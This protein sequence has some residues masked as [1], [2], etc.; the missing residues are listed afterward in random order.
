[1]LTA[2]S[3]ENYLQDVRPD[4]HRFVDL[5]KALVVIGPCEQINAGSESGIR[6]FHFVKATND[7]VRDRLDGVRRESAKRLAASEMAPL[8]IVQTFG[9]AAQDS[10]FEGSPML[11][12]LDELQFADIASAR[13]FFGGESWHAHCDATHRLVDLAASRRFITNSRTVI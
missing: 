5:A 2:Y 1:M 6:V 4:E 13:S 8:A 7:D 10:P 9:L 11:D 3:E 12:G